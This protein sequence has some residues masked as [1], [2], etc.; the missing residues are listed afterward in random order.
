MAQSADA[1]ESRFRRTTCLKNTQPLAQWGRP[2]EHSE[3]D[4]RR[5]DNFSVPLLVPCCGARLQAPSSLS[6]CWTPARFHGAALWPKEFGAR[7]TQQ[8]R[9]EI[10]KNSAS[11]QMVCPTIHCCHFYLLFLFPCVARPP[12]LFGREL[13]EHAAGQRSRAE[14][15]RA[16]QSRQGHGRHH[17]TQ[18][19]DRR[20][21]HTAASACL[22]PLETVLSSGQ[23]ARGW[24]GLTPRDRAERAVGNQ[25]TRCVRLALRRCCPSCRM[26]SRA[27]HGVRFVRAGLGEVRW[28]GDELSSA[29]R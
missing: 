2:S 11:K 21:R 14:Q 15:S 5:V 3:T 20:F 28:T 4:E 13:N 18:H 7:K 10:H 9:K 25:Q 17:S 8:G 6:L 12:G 16:E 27:R 29:A 23:T 24:L 1:N 19:M 26:R 22:V